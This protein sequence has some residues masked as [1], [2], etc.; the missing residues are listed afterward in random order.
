MTHTHRICL[1]W[2]GKM[3]LAF[4]VVLGMTGHAVAEGLQ[5]P[6][7]RTAASLDE[8]HKPAN[9]PDDYVITPNGFFPASCVQHLQPKERVLKDGSI[10]A[11]DGT[12]RLVTACSQ[13]RYTIHGVKIEANSSVS[14]SP[15]ARGESRVSDD[16]GWIVSTYYPANVAIG[17]ISST[18]TV[19]A[20]PTNYN[21]NAYFFFFN[22]LDQNTSNAN[23]AWTIL[24]PVLDWNNFG[25]GYHM[26]NWN[27]CLN[28]VE[29]Y[30]GPFD[31]NSGDAILG[32]ITS[33]CSQNTCS[34]NSAVITSTDETTGES[35]SYSTDAYNWLQYAVS[36]TLEAYGM[37]SCSEY[38]ASKSVQFY[39]IGLWDVNGNYI[40]SSS[41][42]QPE[43]EV[44]SGDL[45]CGFN[46]S[47]SSSNATLSWTP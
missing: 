30:N 4:I 41:L 42:F 36:A 9:V 29:Y 47:V 11:S 14:A 13:P 12:H 3:A 39:N 27:C 35:L 5:E 31:V 44:S 16:N 22:G 2:A 1:A 43:Y 24:Q 40:G 15:S 37:S 8:S 10:E 17:K 26:T 45:Q 6:A 21:P 46:V 19:P 7:L 32:T 28:G 20:A 38:P 34:G 23:N 18:W 25:E 33:T